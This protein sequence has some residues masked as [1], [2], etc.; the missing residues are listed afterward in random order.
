MEKSEWKL[1]P[2]FHQIADTG[3]FDGNYEL[4]NGK[5]SIFTKGDNDE[6]L[7]E[8]ITALN[9]SGIEF[10]LDDSKEIITAESDNLRTELNNMT[11]QASDLLKDISRLKYQ[12][13]RAV[14]L[15]ESIIRCVKYYKETDSDRGG[16]DPEKRLSKLGMVD[17]IKETAEDQLKILNE[18]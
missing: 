14:N 8:I 11:M 3:D 4:T 9:K 2:H 6:G 17:L 7:D 12:K 15:N 10:Y 18:L 13:E 1:V 16:A 5:I